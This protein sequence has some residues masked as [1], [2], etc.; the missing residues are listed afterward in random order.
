[1]PVFELLLIAL[2]M[3]LVVY[4]FPAVAKIVWGCLVFFLILIAIA[5]MLHLTG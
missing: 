2:V 3:A 1:M 4:I 5:Y